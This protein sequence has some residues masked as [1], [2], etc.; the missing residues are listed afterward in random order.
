MIVVCKHV[1]YHATL[2]QFY[3]MHCILIQFDLIEEAYIHLQ[4]ALHDI[5]SFSIIF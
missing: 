3:I 2:T 4:I 1:M 5:G